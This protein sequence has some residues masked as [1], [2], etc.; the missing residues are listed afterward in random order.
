MRKPALRLRQTG[1]LGAGG[2]SLHEVLKGFTSNELD[3]LRRPDLNLLPRFWVHPSARLTGGDFEGAKSD[4]L[5]GLG[6]LNAGFN[7]VDDGVHG[8]L[9][10]SFAAAEGFL[11]GGNEFD[12]VHFGKGK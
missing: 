3:R 12:F 5:N 11:D 9:S 4:Q 7:A 2:K 6:F 1:F 8:P 10:V